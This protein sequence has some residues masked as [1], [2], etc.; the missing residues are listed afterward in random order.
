MNTMTL[1]INLI[2]RVTNAICVFGFFPGYLVADALNGCIHSL[3]NL[4]S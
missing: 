3:L 1:R 4:C 2:K